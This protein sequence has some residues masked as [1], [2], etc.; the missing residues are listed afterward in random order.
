M[1][2]PDSIRTPKKK[3]DPIP[4]DKSHKAFSRVQGLRDIDGFPYMDDDYYG[5]LGAYGFWP[6]DKIPGPGQ[7]LTQDSDTTT[8]L[9]FYDTSLKNTPLDPKDDTIT[10]HLGKIAQDYQ[11][12]EVYS[13]QD[14]GE[15][16]TERI[17][18]K[19]HR[20]L[21]DSTRA[22]QAEMLIRMRDRK[23][24]LL[25]TF[26]EQKPL[27]MLL[28][29]TM[30]TLNVNTMLLE[31]ITDVLDYQEKLYILNKEEK[32]PQGKQ[33]YAE[34]TLINGAEP[35]HLDFLDENNYKNIPSGAVIRD[36]PKHKLFSINVIMSSG[37]N[38]HLATNKPKNSN[39]TTVTMTTAEPYLMEPRDFVIESIN[40]RASG[41]NAAVKV[42]GF[43]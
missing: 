42:I 9:H 26:K 36:F 37:T 19:T 41:A 13:T 10:Q 16:S 30:M 29:Y 24:H 12:G 35:T 2:S 3:T 25:R 17:K 22:Y 11:E 32:R 21:T 18:E 40:L 39:E 5:I 28:E 8:A 23:A 34:M 33:F 14:F 4:D 38:V 27:N 1:V 20:I 31:R 7:K 6:T 43:Y 15:A